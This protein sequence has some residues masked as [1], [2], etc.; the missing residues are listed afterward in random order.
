MFKAL[1]NSFGK[2]VNIF[3]GDTPLGIGIWE[4]GPR[5]VLS[6][7]MRNVLSAGMRNVLS[8][9]RGVRTGTGTVEEEE[10]RGRDRG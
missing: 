1:G 7:G 3:L 5:N 9:G 2:G 6:T 4:S 10:E 8:E